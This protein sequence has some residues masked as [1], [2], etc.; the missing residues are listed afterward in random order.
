MSGAPA[1][2]LL[3]RYQ[4]ALD[5]RQ[6]PTVNVPLP[7]QSPT[8]GMLPGWP[9]WNGAMSGAP[10]LLR[11]FRYQ[12]MVLGSTTPMVVLPLPPQSPTTGIQL[13]PPYAKGVTS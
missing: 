9:Y 8:T 5:S 4:V 3:R 11:F 7:A 10:A 2:L 6:T 13:G 1:L 12:V